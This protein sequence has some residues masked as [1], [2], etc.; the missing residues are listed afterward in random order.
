MKKSVVLSAVMCWMYFYQ[1]DFLESC[2][3]WEVGDGMCQSVHIKRLVGR[4]LFAKYFESMWL[5]TFQPWQYRHVGDPSSKEV[6]KRN[7][8]NTK[9]SYYGTFSQGE[10]QS[11]PSER[12][13]RPIRCMKSEEEAC[14]NN[15]SS[16]YKGCRMTNGGRPTAAVFLRKTTSFKNLQLPRNTD[17]IWQEQLDKH[18]DI[19]PSESRSQEHVRKPNRREITAFL[20]ISK[21]RPDTES[22]FSI[23]RGWLWGDDSRLLDNNH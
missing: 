18:A 7:S 16:W 12:C 21:R 11:Q 14:Y 20:G 13:V 19:Q 5:V 22:L 9:Y 4:R 8:Q 6:N 1:S 10:D 15:I 17:K 2:C 3:H 23:T